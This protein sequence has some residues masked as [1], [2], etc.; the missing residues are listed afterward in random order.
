MAD[1]ID[2]KD[3]SGATKTVATDERTIASATVHIQRVYDLGGTAITAGQ[4]TV[5]NSSTAI[6]AASDT[7]KRI[8]LLNLQTVDVFVG[9]SAATTSMFKLAPGASLTL[10]TT[11]A[12]YGITAAS[13]TPT[14]DAKVHYIEETSV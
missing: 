12:V 11:A 10:Y 5:S 13:Y 1:S 6:A 9:P 7:R 8:V 2:I 14:G 4:T 3:G